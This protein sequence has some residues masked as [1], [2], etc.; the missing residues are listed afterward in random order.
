MTTP[1]HGRRVYGRRWGRGSADRLYW[2]EDVMSQRPAVVG[3]L[4]CEQLIVEERT[5]NITLVNCFTKLK[6]EHF[7]SEPRRLAVFAALVDGLGEVALELVIERL[8]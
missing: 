8:D 5:H 7:P 3:L 1:C 4:V 6:A 2:E